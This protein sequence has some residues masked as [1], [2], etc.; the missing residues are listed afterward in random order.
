MT[1]IADAD[2]ACSDV[3]S[4]VCFWLADDVAAM[5]QQQPADDMAARLEMAQEESLFA[6]EAL[7]LAEAQLYQTRA[8]LELGQGVIRTLLGSPPAI[9]EQRP[10]RWRLGMIGK[11]GIVIAVI[12]A[13]AWSSFQVQITASAVALWV[14]RAR[15]PLGPPPPPPDVRSAAPAPCVPLP[16]PRVRLPRSL[17][18]PLRTEH[19]PHMCQFC[20]SAA[21]TLKEVVV[22]ALQQALSYVKA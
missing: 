8:Q 3:P 4:D 19:V 16:R 6:R 5:A 7:L 22:W 1:K 11:I 12:A 17:P 9:A 21:D 18:L 14:P 15:E 13:V 20:N 2:S 10:R